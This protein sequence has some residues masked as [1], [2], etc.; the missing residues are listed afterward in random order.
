MT[1]STPGVNPLPIPTPQYHFA[2]GSQIFL[3]PFVG[4]QFGP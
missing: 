1:S 2:T 3:G 4:L